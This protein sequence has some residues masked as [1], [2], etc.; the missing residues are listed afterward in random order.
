MRKFFIIALGI[1]LLIV[2]LNIANS[3]KTE[4]ITAK[5]INLQSQ[6]LIKGSGNNMSTE[7]RYLVITEK[8]T[9][10]CES[11]LLQG[12]WNNSDIFWHL[13]KDSTYTF[14]VQGFG[15]GIVFDYRNILEANK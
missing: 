12:K 3:T 6:Q 8:E 15:K 9:F 13:Q 7:I 4:T 1:A 11:S 14:K 2:G 10:V 5:V